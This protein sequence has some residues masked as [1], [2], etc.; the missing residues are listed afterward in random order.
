LLIVDRFQFILV[1]PAEKMMKCHYEVMGLPR[2]CTGEDIKKQYRKLALQWHPD[3]NKGE[4]EMAEK[5]FKEISAAY[6]VLSDPQE[7][8]WYDDHRE[9]I[10]KGK[11]GTAQ[12]EGDTEMEFMPN[13]MAFFNT[14][15]YSGFDDSENGF[16]TV[17]SEI[18]EEIRILEETKGSGESQLPEFGI[19]TS[20]E[21]EVLNFYNNWENFVTT[22]VFYWHDKYNILEA[23]NRQVKRVM[24]KENSKFRDTARR[25]YIAQVKSLVGFVKKRDPRYQ[26][27]ITQRQQRKNEEIAKKNEQKKIDQE[28]RK[29]ERE[30]WQKEAEKEAEVREKER[31][32][33][34]LL[35]DNDSE[36][37]M[38]DLMDS[39]AAEEHLHSMTIE[40]PSSLRQTTIMNK[41]KKGSERNNNNNNNNVGSSSSSRKVP[42]TVFTATTMEVTSLEATTEEG[43]GEEEGGEELEEDE[44]GDETLMFA[45]EVCEKAYKTEMQLNQHLQSKV[46]RKKAQE[47]QKKQKGKGKQKG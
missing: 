15:C 47:L 22:V 18:F 43:I 21:S 7:R 14:S 4:E 37:E 39:F 27:I 36:E 13:I 42:A 3:R 16:Y 38:E 40:S 10:L 35:A 41:S 8:Q 30:K 24:E 29:L 17:Y 33:A 45:C 1:R 32:G 9:A 20:T 44:T 19:S 25:E 46:H 34:F 31:K 28:K 5:A 11:D 26:E 6:T 23:P 2:E 12:D